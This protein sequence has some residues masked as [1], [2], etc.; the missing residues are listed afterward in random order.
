MTALERLTD[1]WINGLVFDYP[2]VAVLAASVALSNPRST[3]RPTEQGTWFQTL[4]GVSG[5][6]LLIGALVITLVFTVAPNDRM[7]RVLDEVGEGL[8]RLVVHSLGGLLMTTAGFAGMFL[9]EVHVARA[10]RV[11]AVVSL[12]V[13]A[14][15]RGARL[16]WL[17]ARIL[18]VLSQRPTPKVVE[19]ARQTWVKPEVGPHDYEVPVRPATGRSRAER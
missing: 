18:M 5:G 8:R 17:L 4:S 3:I 1:G 16:F 14:G 10:V 15:L 19:E 11:A 13:F 7:T 12:I 6:V 9:L 2:I